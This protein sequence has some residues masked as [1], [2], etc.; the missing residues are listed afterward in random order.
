MKNPKLNK[1]TLNIITAILTSICISCAPLGNVNPNKLNSRTTKRNLK[2]T[3]TRANSKN[4]KKTTSHT[5]L[6]NL[7]E[8]SIK[9]L[10]TNNQ[11][12]ENESQNSKSSTQNSQEKTAIS[13]LEEI[14]KDLETQ[15]KQGNIQI[16]EIDTKYDFLETF[17]LQ[18]GDYFMHREKMKLKKIIYSSLNYD[19]EKILTLKE[20]LERLDKNHDNRT[21]ANKFLQTSKDIQLQIEDRHLTKIK[22]ILPTLSKENAEELLQKTNHDLKIKENFV[23]ALNETIKAYNQNYQDIKKNDAALANHIK[24]KYS[25]PL[26]LLN[27]AD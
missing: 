2:K 3:K 13:K 16:A 14:G 27:Q 20:I 22:N 19:T 18:R 5:N 17:K 25:H 15:E 26:Y 6:E 1:S 12:F 4:L 7:S 23:K 8:N 11:N 10:S 24:E 21:I 9:N